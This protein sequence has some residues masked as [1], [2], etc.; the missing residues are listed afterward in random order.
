MNPRERMLTTLNHR[1]PDRVPIDLGG[2]VT[3]IT[4][5]ANES[6]KAYLGIESDD[7]VIDRIQQLSAPSQAILDSSTCG[8]PL[9]FPQRLT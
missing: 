8:H 6:L 7:P 4:R 5:G 1:E 2:I 9:S 3:G